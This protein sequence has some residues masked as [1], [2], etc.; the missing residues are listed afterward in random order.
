MSNG[1][2]YFWF[3][4]SL[5]CDEEITHIKFITAPLPMNDED[6]CTIDLMEI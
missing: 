6:Q 2:H 4:V 1:H 5:C 3:S